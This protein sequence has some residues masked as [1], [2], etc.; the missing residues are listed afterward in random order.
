VMSFLSPGS[1]RG[2]STNRRETLLHDR[3]LVRLDK[4]SPKMGAK[5]CKIS[6]DFLPLQICLR[7]SPE[8]GKKSKIGQICDLERLLPRRVRRKRS[9][10]LL[11]TISREFHVSLDLLKCTFL[12]DY[13]SAHRG[14]CALKFL[15]ALEIDQA[16]IAHTRSG[17]WVPPPKKFNRENIKFGLKLSVLATITSGL[18]GVS[19]QNIFRTTCCE[20]GVITWV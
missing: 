10:E 13:I 1:L 2:L 16:L 19:S 4:L 5:T 14:C 18:V 15:H 3:K 7:I 20:A 9:G 6:V 11:S 17:T 12:A 8:R